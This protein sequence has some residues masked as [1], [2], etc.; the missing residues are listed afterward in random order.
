M[1]IK[2]RILFV[3]LIAVFLSLISCT[4][5]MTKF[6]AF[7]K[8]YEEQPVTI[9]VLPP[10]NETTAAD[11][12]DYYTTTIAEPLSEAGFY[13]YSIEVI[14]QILQEQ[15]LYEIENYDNLP[16][17]TFAEYFG[18]DAIL[19]I[20]IIKWDTNYYVIGGNVTVSIDFKLIS[21]KTFQELWKYN[22]TI[23]ID[24]TGD[25]GDTGG[26]A[27]L[28][29]KVASTAIKTAATDYVPQ[30]KKAN[31][32]ALKSI[33]FGKYHR[34]YNKDRDSKVVKKDKTSNKTEVQSTDQKSSR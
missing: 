31:F 11:A 15:G 4:P 20:K 5:K 23:K 2:L 29:V 10:I 8:M 7:P 19:I 30:A 24:T 21:T 13:V 28:L 14:N 18:A 3:L 26:L 27:G 16:L 17:S 1:S 9:L 25:S 34:Q 6:E 33:P 12:T 22:G 32:E